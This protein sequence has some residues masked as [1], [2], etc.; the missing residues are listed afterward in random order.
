VTLKTYLSMPV[1]DECA[2]AALPD[3]YALKRLYASD[4]ARY[5]ALFAKVGQ[6]WLW[7]SRLLL[8]DAQLQQALNHPHCHAH[9]VTYGGE[10]I[11]LFELQHH[12]GPLDCPE[13]ESD[14]AFLGLDMAARGR[15]LGTCLLR[16]AHHQAKLNGAQ[17]LTINTCQLDDPRALGFYQKM[18]FSVEK[19][20]LEIL[21]DPR[22]LGLYPK[23]SAPHIALSP[24]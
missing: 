8:K 23:E 18:G 10:D 22:H 20:A 12:T 6:N 1:S 2:D 21:T 17:K 3:G 4:Y 14:L 13:T 9:V 16:M 11:G 5:R 19:L 7:F 24:W 15:G